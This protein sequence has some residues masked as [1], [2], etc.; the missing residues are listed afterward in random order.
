MNLVQI[1]LA[2]I[3]IFAHHGVHEEERVVGTEFE[4]SMQVSFEALGTITELDQT[5]NYV[6]LHEIIRRE[7]NEPRPLLETVGMEIANRVKAS[8]PIAREI[9]IT[10]SK[11]HPPLANF[12]GELGISIVN[13]Y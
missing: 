13:R 7:M 8:F 9:N 1:N 12:R 2:K 4:V 5:V 6:A 3:R 11:L 10:I